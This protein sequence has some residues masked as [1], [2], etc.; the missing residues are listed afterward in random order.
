MMGSSRLGRW[1]LLCAACAFVTSLVGCGEDNPGFG[2]DGDGTG[3]GLVSGCGAAQ[4]VCAAGQVCD[5]TMGVCVQACA[6]DADC[7]AGACCNGRCVDTTSNPLNCGACGNAC[8][9]DATCGGGSCNQLVCDG[10]GGGGGNVGGDEDAGVG[11]GPMLGANGCAA[12]EQCMRDAGGVAQCKC[13]VGPSC[14]AGESCTS[15]ACTCNGGVCVAGQICCGTGCADTLSD[16]NNCGGCGNVCAAGLICS[17]G[18]CACSDATYTECDGACVNTQN[19]ANHCGACGNVCTGGSTCVLGACTCPNAGDNYC[20]GQCFAPD[21]AANC[22]ACGNTCV[23]D[24]QCREDGDHPLGCYCFNYNYTSCDGTCVKLDTDTDN[25]GTCGTVCDGGANQCN[26]GACECPDPGDT[27]CSEVCVDLQTDDANCGSCGF[28]CTDGAQ[29]V[30]GT[31]ECPVGGEFFCED[32]G[33][34]SCMAGN[35]DMNCG[36][37]CQQCEGTSACT[38]AGGGTFECTCGGGDIYCIDNNLGACH[39]PLTTAKHC[40]GCGI[41]CIAGETCVDGACTCPA[42]GE[43]YCD[44]DGDG[45]YECIPTD[46]DPN[47]CGGCGV[48]C[49]GGVDCCK[50]ACQDDPLSSDLNDLNNCGACGEVCNSAVAF[51]TDACEFRCDGDTQTGFECGTYGLFGSPKDSCP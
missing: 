37:D 31:C 5:A 11:A 36:A 41:A 23:G 49:A 4:T 9:A 24:E 44:N 20:D 28:A 40:G 35:T 43:S 1:L 22:G 12:G 6:M 19:N 2:Y 25:C 27:E 47:N 26:T 3:G 8:A 21:D 14:G 13:G 32:G 18:Q 16:A 30:D 45:T 38:D 7:G 15:G 33:S 50:G 10:G 39:D 34:Y 51:E 42:A 46:S 29:C 48:V 17:G